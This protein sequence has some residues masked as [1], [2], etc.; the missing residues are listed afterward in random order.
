MNV[1]TIKEVTQ[2]LSPQFR[3]P[4][5]SFFLNIIDFCTEYIESLL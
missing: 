2:I 5:L 1:S 3:Y 4:V